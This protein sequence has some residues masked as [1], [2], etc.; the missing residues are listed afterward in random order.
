MLEVVLFHLITNAQILKYESVHRQRFDSSCGFA[1]VSSLLSYYYGFPVTE[2]LVI[3][4][5][6]TLQAGTSDVKVFLSNAITG[7]N[8][9]ALSL[10]DISD[11]LTEYGVQNKAY[12]MSFDELRKIIEKYA[13]VLVHY[14]RPQ[15]HFLLLTSV[16]SDEWVTALDPARGLEWI[17]REEFISR[18]SGVVLLTICPNKPPNRQTIENST[19]KS[20]FQRRL[21]MRMICDR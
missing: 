6:F 5:Y 9:Y 1:A 12:K 21:L 11:I 13:P 14:D 4:N 19:R 17:S 15:T 18:W 10:A 20:H 7:T 3:S 16:D 8:I 2:P